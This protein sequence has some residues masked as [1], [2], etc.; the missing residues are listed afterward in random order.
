[1]HVNLLNILGGKT[2]KLIMEYLPMGSLKDYLPRNKHQIDHNKLLLY[3]IQIC[4][5]EYTQLVY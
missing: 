4:Q 3:A 1:M 5:V 2:F